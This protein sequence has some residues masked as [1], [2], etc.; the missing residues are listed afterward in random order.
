MRAVFQGEAAIPTVYHGPAGTGAHGD[1][2]F[3]PV[4]ELVRATQ[5]YL[6]MLQHLWAA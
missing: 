5:V 3:M 6:T 2:E 4:A 1:V